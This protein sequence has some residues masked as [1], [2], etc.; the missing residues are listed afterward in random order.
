MR[1]PAEL[2]LFEDEVHVWQARLSLPAERL[3]DLAG[4]LDPD[5]L[6]ASERFRFQKDR[7][8]FI[9]AR[10]LLRS[11]L[12]YYL[13]VSPRALRFRYGAHGKPF[14]A[15][16]FGQ[17]GLRFNVSHS[18]ETALYAIARDREVGVDLEYMRAD[19]GCEEVAE[20]FFSRCENTALRGYPAELRHRAFFTCWTLKEAVVKAHGG[21]LSIP[22]DSFDVFLPGGMPK[23]LLSLWDTAGRRSNWSL[24]E[25]HPGRGYVGALAVEGQ[26]CRVALWSPPT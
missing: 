23:P 21:G 17:H 1:A 19:F 6:C 14:L 26:G 22:L 24:L 10:G 8:R 25:I 18:H 7:A 4:T 20:R 12:G 11:I 2:T 13:G 9:A 15:E 16:P 3:A 5:E